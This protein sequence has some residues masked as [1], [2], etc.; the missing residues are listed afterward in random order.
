MFRDNSGNHE[1]IKKQFDTLVRHAMRLGPAIAI[2][3]PWPQPLG[4]LEQRRATLDTLGIRL[5]R[6]SELLSRRLGLPR[7][8][9]TLRDTQAP[10]PR[11]RVR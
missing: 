5:V 9:L 6:V 8:Q 4:G 3:H 7:G 10:R 1:Q 2:G 11:L